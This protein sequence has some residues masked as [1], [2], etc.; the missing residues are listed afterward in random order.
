MASQRTEF[1]ICESCFWCASILRGG[2]LVGRCPC[3]KSN[4]LESIPIRTGE[5]YR[6]DCSITRGVMP[7]FA[8]ADY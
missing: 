7:D 4:M 2:T 3:C 8:P 6:F 5:P 1:L